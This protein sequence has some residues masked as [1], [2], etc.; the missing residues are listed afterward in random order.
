M[1]FLA[2]V[3]YVICYLYYKYY[4]TVFNPSRLLLPKPEEVEE[5]RIK[6]GTGELYAW[7]RIVEDKPLL[8]YFHGNN[9]NLTFRSYVVSLSKL[10]GYSLLLPDYRGFGKSPGYPNVH[11]LQEDALAVYAYAKTKSRR[12]ILWGESLGGYA[13][14][15]CLTQHQ[16]E[17]LVLFNTFSNLTQV[18]PLCLRP[19]FLYFPNLCNQE[20]LKHYKGPS[21][22]IHSKGDTFIPFSQA[23]RNHQLL[24]GFFLEIAGDHSTPDFTLDNFYTLLDFLQVKHPREEDCQA[25]IEVAKRGF[26]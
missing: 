8:I 25:W 9:L 2:T 15:Y 12:I 6:S 3:I 26:S 20:F 14:S 17:K 16:P 1:L 23:E 7:E 21:L 13:A 10:L 22:V 18:S 24:S 11:S 19:L 5:V 4:K